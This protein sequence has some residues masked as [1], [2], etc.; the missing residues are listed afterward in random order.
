MR[1]CGREKDP[2]ISPSVF[3]LAFPR[4]EFDMVVRRPATN[5][6]ELF[7]VKHA[8]VSDDRQARHLRDVKMLAEVE[9]RFGRVSSRSVLYRGKSFC[10]EDGVR[11]RNVE[12]FLCTD[13]N[14]LCC[15]IV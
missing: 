14:S 7:E 10:A 4:G 12:E 9:R 6:C 13:V 11:W 15:K 5:E 8:M 2:I 1:V 3:K